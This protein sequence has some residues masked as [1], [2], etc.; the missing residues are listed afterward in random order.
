MLALIELKTSVNNELALIGL[1]QEGSGH[2][3]ALKSKGKEIS[4]N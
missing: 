4:F 2:F 1:A 3:M